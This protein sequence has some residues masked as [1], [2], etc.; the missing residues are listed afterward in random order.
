MDLPPPYYV[1]SHDKV[2][3]SLQNPKYLTVG[4]TGVG[5]VYDFGGNDTNN[6]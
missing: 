2:P 1:D 5:E 3:I 6:Y 4:G